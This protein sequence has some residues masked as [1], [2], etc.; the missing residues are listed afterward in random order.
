LL[1]LL[2]D[3]NSFEHWIIAWLNTVFVLT[4]GVYAPLIDSKIENPEKYQFK[5]P[6]WQVDLRFWRFVTL[7][8][9]INLPIKYAD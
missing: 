7:F 3:Q 9:A 4:Y 5:R 2:H 8:S 1:L 6:E